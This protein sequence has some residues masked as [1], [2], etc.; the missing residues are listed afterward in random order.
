MEIASCVINAIVASMSSLL[1]LKQPI[2]RDYG[3]YPVIVIHKNP[4][5][6]SAGFDLFDSQYSCTHISGVLYHL[7]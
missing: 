7:L 4:D 2:N 1:H 3:L 5:T 6:V